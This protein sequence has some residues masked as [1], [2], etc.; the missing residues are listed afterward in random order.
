MPH[1][2]ANN[3][4]IYYESQGKGEPVVLISGLGSNI[5]SWTTQ[6]PIYSRLFR[7]IYFDNRGTGRSDKPGVDYTTEIMADDTISLLDNLGIEKASFVGKSM[8]GMIAQWIGIKYPERVNKLVLGCCSAS[9]DEIGNEILRTAREIATKAGM[10]TVW[11]TALFLSYS[12]GYIQANLSSIKDNISKVP[13]SGENLTGYLRQSM[14]CEAHDAA[15]RVSRIRAKTLII[16]GKNDFITPPQR[17]EELASQIRNS[18]SIGYDA[19]HGFWRENQEQVDN[20]IIEFL[21]GN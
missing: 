9:R 4:R 5:S 21:S 20:D 18:K 11:L 6:I 8:G 15:G 3:I 10:K 16:Y 12:R 14:A 2:I 17:S 1:T 13:D 7:V 19:G